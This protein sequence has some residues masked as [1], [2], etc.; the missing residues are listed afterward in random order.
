MRNDLRHIS[1]GPRI[2]FGNN[3]KLIHGLVPVKIG[4]LGRVV[5]SPLF[6]LA[7]GDHAT[8]VSIDPESD[9]A[10]CVEIIDAPLMRAAWLARKALHPH[11]HGEAV[12]PAAEPRGGTPQ[13]M[14]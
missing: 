10:R 9:F 8:V 13:R 2:G 14:W 3:P 7:C 1:R 6:E 12:A 11:L 5:L 4:G